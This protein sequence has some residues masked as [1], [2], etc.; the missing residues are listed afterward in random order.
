MNNKETYEQKILKSNVGESV[1]EENYVTEEHL[2]E[3]ENFVT[4]VQD[5]YKLETR[6][7]AEDKAQELIKDY[8]KRESELNNEGRTR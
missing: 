2:Q 8:Q 3:Y 4:K 1:A 6:E 7:Q 5:K